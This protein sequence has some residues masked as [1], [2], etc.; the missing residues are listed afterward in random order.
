MRARHDYPRRLGSMESH[1]L[2]GAKHRAVGVW[3]RS[4]K[5]C[6]VPRDVAAGWSARIT[7]D[8]FHRLAERG[9]ATVVADP[10]ARASRSIRLAVRRAVRVR[11]LAGSIGQ[12]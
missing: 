12:T 6:V 11:L 2:G 1:H 10:A 5:W 3:I 8:A 7:R 4:R 9:R